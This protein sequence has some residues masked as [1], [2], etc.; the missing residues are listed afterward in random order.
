MREKPVVFEMMDELGIELIGSVHTLRGTVRD[1]L[2]EVSRFSPANVCVELYDP[3][4]PTRSFEIEAARERYLDRFVCIDRPITVTNS[5]YMTGTPGL[6][7]L[8]ESIVKY[9]FLPFNVISIIA[10]NNFSGIYKKLSGGDF[11]TFGW[12]RRDALA[13]IYE[14]DEYMAGTLAEKLRSGELRGKSVVLVG[15]RHVP[16]MKCILEAFRYTNDIGSYYAGGRVYD[17]FSLAELDEPYTL[18]YDQSRRNFIRNRIIE[19]TVRS[20]F[21]PAYL[22]IL[23]FLLA[24][25]VIM[26]TATA[27]ALIKS[28][29]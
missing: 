15:R 26:A 1:I 5:R 14:R 12:S 21:L 19:T 22:L 6:V 20:I 11:F 8:K 17:V 3:L 23:F 29:F 7:Y 24:A 9:F 27:L 13:Y 10:F 18:S 25:F 28:I 16:G 2:M 4:Q